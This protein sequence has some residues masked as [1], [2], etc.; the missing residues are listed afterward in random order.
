MVYLIKSISEINQLK[1]APKAKAYVAERL[2]DNQGE[3][4]EI[5]EFSHFLFFALAPKG[6]K[7]EDIEDVRRRGAKLTKRFNALKLKEV[8]LTSLGADE[9]VLLALA[10]GMA[11]A[12]Y[13]FLKYFSKSEAK[14]NSLRKVAIGGVPAAR[15]QELKALVESVCLS[16]DLINE[17]VIT[18]GAE[19]LADAAMKM[20]K[21]VGIKAEVLNKKKI[22]SLKMGGLL[23][24]NYGSIDPPT[25]TI[26]EYKPPSRS[27]QNP[28]CW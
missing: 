9:T 22:E 5:N 10:E 12:N 26:L 15:V 18:L 23:A 20:A 6:K 3:A 19:Q 27:M 21:E 8:I 7:T 2:K 11:L 16:R 13:Q 24:V 28:S 14:A 25:F 17:P 4:V 1:L